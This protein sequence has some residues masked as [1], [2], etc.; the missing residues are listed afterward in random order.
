MVVYYYHDL[1]DLCCYF[2]S[3][4]TT[5]V[6]VISFLTQPPA[7][8][9][10][11][12]CCVL[13]SFGSRFTRWGILRHASV[14]LFVVLRSSV[15]VLVGLRSFVLCSSVRCSVCLREIRDCTAW[16]LRSGFD[17]DAAECVCVCVCSSD[18]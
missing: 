16:S 7:R 8:S 13:N 14:H 12:Q 2:V 5:Y 9:V 15:F 4:A 10:T 1:V 18:M 6:I 11:V 3:Y 17:G